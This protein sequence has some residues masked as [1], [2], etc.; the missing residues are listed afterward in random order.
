MLLAFMRKLK[1]CP[2][3]KTYIGK[4][5]DIETQKEENPK[6][7]EKVIKEQLLKLKITVIKIQLFAGMPQIFFYLPSMFCF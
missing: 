4:E 5:Y 2:G 1:V 3:K 6:T 7:T